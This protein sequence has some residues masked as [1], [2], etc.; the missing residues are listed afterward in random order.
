MTTI[1]LV[2]DDPLQ[3]SLVVSLLGKRFGEVRRATDAGEAFCL[4]EQPEF[5][6]RLGLV[7][8]GHRR[9]GIGGPAFV[10]ELRTRIPH[11]PVLVLG[12]AS[13][14]AADYDTSD[15]VFL[16]KPFAGEKMLTLTGQMLAHPKNAVA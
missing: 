12:T 15:V 10:S 8:Y 1:L 3:A 16:E 5:A 11:L 2:D 14:S 9:C 7:I 4:I 13:E 6:N